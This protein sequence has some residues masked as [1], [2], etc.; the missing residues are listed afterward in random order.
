MLGWRSAISEL[1]SVSSVSI[2]WREIELNVFSHIYFTIMRQLTGN[3]S[4]YW[5]DCSVVIIINQRS[6]V[7]VS[8]HSVFVA[9]LINKEASAYT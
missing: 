2:V 3:F 6:S 9:I 4:K 7:N 8:Y 5:F 1:Y